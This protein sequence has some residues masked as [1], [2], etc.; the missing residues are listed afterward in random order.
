MGMKAVNDSNEKRMSDKRNPTRDKK[1]VVQGRYTI[2]GFVVEEPL[3]KFTIP[4][5]LCCVLFLVKFFAASR[6]FFSQNFANFFFQIFL[7][8]PEIFRSF[9]FR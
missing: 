8:V 5:G 1:T 7:F 4:I 2:M 6:H 3:D 9:I